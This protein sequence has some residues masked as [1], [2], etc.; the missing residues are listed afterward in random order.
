MATTLQPTAPPSLAMAQALAL[1]NGLA[2]AAADG[3]PRG[4]GL[5]AVAA[6]VPTSTHPD[7]A[8]ES[9]TWL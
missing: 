8:A 4:D 2:P 7:M 9:L 1:L 6:A 3:T 5:H